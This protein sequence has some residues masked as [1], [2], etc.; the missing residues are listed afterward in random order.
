MSEEVYN[1]P[2]NIERIEGTVA[3]VTCPC[4]RTTRLCLGQKAAAWVCQD[5]K[6]NLLLPDWDES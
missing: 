5:C 2:T 1:K 3:D 4:G 6:E